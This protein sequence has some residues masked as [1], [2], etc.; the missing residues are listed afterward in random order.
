M[1]QSPPITVEAIQALASTMEAS[2]LPQSLTD[3]LGGQSAASSNELIQAITQTL[4]SAT[5]E[6]LQSLQQIT[7]D[8]NLLQAV[9]S[10]VATQEG[11]MGQVRQTPG[12]R[13]DSTGGGI[14]SPTDVLVSFQPSDHTEEVQ[15]SSETV[16]HE[17]PVSEAVEPPH[18]DSS[19]E[20]LEPEAVREVIQI[21]SSS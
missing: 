12:E 21:E 15:T 9:T 6:Q 20:P 11:G 7:S 4:A 2:V 3:P 16:H 17:E 1:L 8:L 5:P 10:I 14:S 18:V 13:H 19:N